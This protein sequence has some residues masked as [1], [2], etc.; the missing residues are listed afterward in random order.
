MINDYY[1]NDEKDDDNGDKSETSESESSDS[2]IG[3]DKDVSDEFMDD[4]EMK[5]RA[6]KELRST[7]KGQ[8]EQQKRKLSGYQ[9]KLKVFEK[10]FLKD[11][12][13]KI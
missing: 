4:K 2:S 11:E 8:R 13:L 6:F 7:F 10:D 9:V 1:G 5:L 3:L 12:T